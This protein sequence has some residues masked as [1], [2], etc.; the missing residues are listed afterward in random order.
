MSSETL[1]FL[2]TA[3]VAGAISMVA[4]AFAVVVNRLCP[5]GHDLRS[6]QTGRQAP[7]KHI[8][9]C[10]TPGEMETSSLDGWIHHILQSDRKGTKDNITLGQKH[11]RGNLS[12]RLACLSERIDWEVASGDDLTTVNLPAGSG[13]QPYVILVLVPQ[14]PSEDSNVAA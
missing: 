2:S 5:R 7:K 3:S 6:V 12:S 13:D 14:P 10:A 8:N 11:R 9:R 1:F 4:R